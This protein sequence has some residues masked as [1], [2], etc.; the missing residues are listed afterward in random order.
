MWSSSG[1]ECSNIG[2]TFWYL[3]RCSQAKEENLKANEKVNKY[4][5]RCQHLKRKRE[6][7]RKIHDKCLKLVRDRQ[8]QYLSGT[9][10]HETRDPVA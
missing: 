7:W 10:V 9:E 1:K 4:Y 5:I 3:N 2:P 8:A 6:N